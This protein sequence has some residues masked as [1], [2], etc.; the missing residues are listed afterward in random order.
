MPDATGLDDNYE[1]NDDDAEDD[2][3]DDADRDTSEIDSL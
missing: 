3:D 2:N 1:E